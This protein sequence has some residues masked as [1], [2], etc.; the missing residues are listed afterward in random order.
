MPA[1]KVQLFIDSASPVRL[2]PD[3]DSE[4]YTQKNEWAARSQVGRRLVYRHGSFQRIDLPV[5]F[6]SSAD[7]SIIESWW[8]SDAD[9]FLHE[10]STSGVYS[11]HMVND[12][13]P[14]PTVQHPYTTQFSG[15]IAL[16]GAFDTLA[17]LPFK[18]E[19]PPEV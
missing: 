8:L 6:V 10:E 19:V 11:V 4:S 7:R 18:E 17:E 9:I 12:S 5:Q 2:M 15:T 16:E 3:W 1:G 14:I 13:H